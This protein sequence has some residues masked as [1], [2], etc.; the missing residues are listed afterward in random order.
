MVMG[1]LPPNISASKQKSHILNKGTD[2][3]LRRFLLVR[4]I[5]LLVLLIAIALMLAFILAN[6]LI[7][8]VA[9]PFVFIIICWVYR[10][11]KDTN[12]PLYVIVL[13]SIL[14]VAGAIHLDIIYDNVGGDFWR[15][16][17][18][19]GMAAMFFPLALFLTGVGHLCYQITMKRR[20]HQLSQQQVLSSLVA[21]VVALLA[22][23][24]VPLGQERI[25]FFIDFFMYL[26]TCFDKITGR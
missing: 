4:K 26:L 10:Q 23:V 24:P 19:I 22:I 18:E 1:K 13:I 9:L 15:F 6:F 5:S 20:G 17:E 12:I 16:L 3:L 14:P 11:L 8:L 2:N 7:G 21:L 25:G